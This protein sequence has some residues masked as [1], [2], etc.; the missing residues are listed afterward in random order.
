[1]HYIVHY[2]A[3]IYRYNF[4]FY[5]NIVCSTSIGIRLVLSNH[6]FNSYFIFQL[7]FSKFGPM[8]RSW[9]MRYEAKHGYFKRLA[10]FIGNYTNV[11]VSLVECHQTR[12]CYLRSAQAAKARD[13]EE[14]LFQCAAMFLNKSACCFMDHNS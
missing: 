3:H 9:C 14:I 10:L 6:F 2:P 4:V 12:I 8:V 5:G 1:M 13:E 7:F 11:A